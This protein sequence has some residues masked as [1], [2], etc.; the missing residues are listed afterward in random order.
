MVMILRLDCYLKCNGEIRIF[1]KEIDIEHF[2]QEQ[3]QKD[4]LSGEESVP[5]WFDK[6][7]T[8]VEVSIDSIEL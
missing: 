5:S 7:K 8:T 4:I 3:I 6:D 2:I 1:H